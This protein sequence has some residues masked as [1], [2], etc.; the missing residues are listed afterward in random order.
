AF[1]RINSL[2][3]QASAGGSSLISTAMLKE[4][5]VRNR[6]TEWIYIPKDPTQQLGRL[7]RAFTMVNQVESI[8]GKVFR[9]RRDGILPRKKGKELYEEAL[10]QNII[11]A[12]ELRLLQ[13]V[14]PIRLDAIMVD[15]FSEEEFH[16]SQTTPNPQMKIA[17]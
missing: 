16:S 13:E 14:E 6:L 15:D 2:G 7:E 12:E 10:R 9:A 8:E 5:E 1:S 11:N 3:S 17:K 4:G